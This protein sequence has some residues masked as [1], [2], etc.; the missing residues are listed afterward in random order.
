MGRFLVWLAAALLPLAGCQ[1]SGERVV[2]YCAQDREFA[3]G[4]LAEFTARTGIVVETRYDTEA[5]KSVSLYEALVR[6]KDRPR[7]DVFWNNEILL[8]LRLDESGLLAPYASPSAA[9]FPAWSTSPKQTWQAFAARARILLVDRRLPEAERPRALED[10]LQ[11]K[12]QGKVVMAKPF[13]GTT[14]TH[15]ACLASVLGEEEAKKYF[16]ALK[17]NAAVVAGNKQ[18]AEAVG[19]GQ[20]PVGLTDT[21]DAII[22]VRRGKE[23]LI[24]YPDA[25]GRGTLF[26]P[27]AVSLLKNCPNPSAGKKLIDYLL[28]AE[29][30]RKLAEGPSAQIPLNPRVV[31]A[32]FDLATP[33]TT[34]AMDAD[35]S[36]AAKNWDQT[37]TL[38]REIFGR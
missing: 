25:Q 8:T 35:F 38:L 31:L 18:V 7:C 13:F 10:L 3:E 14:A 33:A 37:Q 9:G 24:V 4:L 34:K 6:E 12:W 20:Y 32:K 2:L 36:S 22:E 15:L 26:L 23:V 11:P 1:K 29:V 17:A 5:S 27:N 19:S 21:D 16:T 28:S 30:E